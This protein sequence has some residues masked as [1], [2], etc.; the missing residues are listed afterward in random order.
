MK[1]M[2]IHPGKL[3]LYSMLSLADFFLT[4][5]LVQQ[6]GGEVYE[7]NPIANAW[8]SAFGWAGLVIY[9]AL[10]V[11]VVVGVV[12]I[13]SRS[14]PRTS[15]N[16]LLF[17]CCIVGGVVLYSC[18]LSGF[19]GLQ[20]V[21]ASIRP[22][23][24]QLRGRNPERRKHFDQ[25]REELIAQRCTLAEAVARL[26]SMEHLPRSPWIASLRQRYP[27]YSHEEYLAIHLINCVLRIHHGDEAEAPH[28]APRLYADFESMYG[29]PFPE[30]FLEPPVRLQ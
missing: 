23:L 30:M 9:K 8:L 11:L 4:Y 15:G 28:L 19:G 18:W 2:T 5:H 3:S 16:I 13:I 20:S 12:V 7:S 24:P 1:I 6:G 29:K 17:G 25:L 22:T 14:R 26:A 10:A 27:D 21:E